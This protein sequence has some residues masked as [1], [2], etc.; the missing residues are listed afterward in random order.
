MTIAIFKLW[1][2]RGKEIID[3]QNAGQYDN[4]N[5]MKEF[6]EDLRS[7]GTQMYNQHLL[8]TQ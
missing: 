6:I 3:M 8:P 7:K 1:V 2:L 5:L 4:F